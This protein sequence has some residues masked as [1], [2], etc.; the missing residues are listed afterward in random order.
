MKRQNTSEVTK[1]MVW[2]R[3]A[4]H[5]ELCGK[6]LLE[7]VVSL[8]NLYEGEVAHIR[9]AAMGPR[10]PAGYSEKDA[11]LLTN[12]PNNLMLLCPNCH[13]SIDKA[14]EGVFT[15]EDLIDRHQGYLE[16]IQV[17]ATTPHNDFGA[18][19]IVL[20]K[21][22]S[23]KARIDPSELQRA[24]FAQGIR[25]NHRPLPIELPDI[26][27]ARDQAY[28]ESV[29]HLLSR[30][31]E[32]DFSAARSQMGDDPCI[33][34]TGLADI[35]SLMIAGNLLGDRRRR[36]V[37]NL[38]RDT[39]LQAPNPAAPLPV[40]EYIP[41]R[42]GSGPVA[43]VLNISATIPPIDVLEA[44]PGARIATFAAPKPSVHHVQHHGFIAA[45]R[46]QLQIQLSALEAS[47]AEPIHVFAAIPPG[48]AI[49]FGALL[50]MNHQHGYCIF[51]RQGATNAFS[52]HYDFHA[53]PSQ[54]LAA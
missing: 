3:A 53:R 52:R 17:A 19:I 7:E 4:G 9:P 27:S 49:E 42:E 48:F 46:E 22:F 23:T 1:T 43:L 44:L 47:V 16:R 36:M 30:R 10:A 40:Y 32:L 15:T 54:E 5:C 41:P 24:M 45:F 14:D 13:T 12:D 2:I 33:A 18:G 31:I 20:G 21:H 35:P 8:K 37:F 28:Y 6:N 29:R 34:I 25:P 50:S 26:I 38:D 11:Q 39:R 51:D